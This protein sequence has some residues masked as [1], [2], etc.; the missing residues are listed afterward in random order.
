MERL[1]K[2]QMQYLMSWI[3]EE[4]RKRSFYHLALLHGVA[5]STVQR[6][7]NVLVAR[8]YLTE[9]YELTEDGRRY[10]SWYIPRHQSLVNWLCLHEIELSMA[11]STAHAWLADTEDPVIDMLLKNC[12]ICSICKKVAFEAKERIL[13]DIDLSEYIPAGVYEVGADFFKDG[14]EVSDREHSMA[15]EAFE[16]PARLVISEED[17]YVELKRIKV[18]HLS[19]KGTNLVSGKLK[20]MDYVVNGE[21]EKALI[22]G[23]VVRIPIRHIQWYCSSNELELWGQLR[24]FVTC[25]AGICH[26]PKR[27]ALL[28]VRLNQVVGV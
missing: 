3:Q 17:S 6:T 7:M 15:D 10:M 8:G 23:E 28:K 4:G 1:T 19:Y 27:P 22:N 24:I 18:V 14:K 20:S 13:K 5:K 12:L 25:T 21:R 9:N 2:V 16:K 26:M 11:R